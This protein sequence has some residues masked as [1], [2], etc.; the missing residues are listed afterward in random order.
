MVTETARKTSLKSKH[1]RNCDCFAIIPS[2]SHFTMLTKNPATGLVSVSAVKVSTQNLTL[3][4]VCS[5]SH[6]NGKCGIFTLLFCRE[7]HGLVHKSVAHV[8]RDYFSTLHQS[9]S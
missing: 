9:N 1:L 7:R 3:T 4:V 2:C 6:Q 8:Q 5:S